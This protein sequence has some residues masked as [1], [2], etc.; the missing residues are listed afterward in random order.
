MARRSVNAKEKVPELAEPDVAEA[1]DRQDMFSLEKTTQFHL[2]TLNNRF[3][4]WLSGYYRNKHEL[5]IAAWRVVA[6]LGQHEPLSAK[7]VSERT[8][9]DAH[10]VTRAINQLVKLGL[11][12]RSLDTQDRRKISLRLTAKGRRVYA[13][14]IPVLQKGLRDLY[15]VLDEEEHARFRHILAK[16]EAHSIAV[17]G[18]VPDG[19]DSDE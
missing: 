18:A 19:S 8:V 12:R 15:S 11:A 17:F 1:G 14:V 10:R 9:M 5:S 7:E 6:I 3:T 4:L 16:I 13:D 2:N